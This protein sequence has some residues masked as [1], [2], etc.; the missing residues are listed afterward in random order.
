MITKKISQ[1]PIVNA[2]RYVTVQATLSEDS[3]VLV[4]STIYKKGEDI[5]LSE[6]NKSYVFST[7]GNM[8]DQTGK[9]VQANEDGEFPE[10][11]IPETVFL[12]NLP[13]DA[14]TDTTLWARVEKL[15]DT[16]IS[17]LDSQGKFV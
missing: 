16:R 17:S 14:F 9:P 7:Q 15:V 13:A 5:V 6:L 4:C 12:K 8:V 1:N 2:D 3:V 10:G 11:S